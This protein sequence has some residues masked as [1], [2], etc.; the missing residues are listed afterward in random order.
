M[1]AGQDVEKPWLERRE[2]ESHQLVSALHGVGGNLDSHETTC[3]FI[4]ITYKYENALQN[5]LA[6]ASL[7]LHT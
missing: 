2:L 1:C 7:L 5:C 3:G 4:F 6:Y